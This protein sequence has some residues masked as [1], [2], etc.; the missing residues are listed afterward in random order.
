MKIGLILECGPEGADKKVCEAAVRKLVPGCEVVSRTLDKK[1]KLLSECGAV[2][3]GLLTIDKCTRVLVVWDLYPGW[4]TDDEKPCRKADRSAAL[5]S[6]AAAS[7]GTNRNISLVC[8]SEELEAWLIG[9]VAAIRETIHRHLDPSRHYLTKK[10]KAVKTGEKTRNPKKHLMKVFREHGGIQYLDRDHAH[11][12]FAN[13]TDLKSLKDL[14][15]FKR[16]AEK[17]LDKSWP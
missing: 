1:P 3:H 12:I 15:S 14:P 5:A 17:L 13:I 11:A 7:L 2:A 4:R 16:F 8:I 10:L 9:N 6:I